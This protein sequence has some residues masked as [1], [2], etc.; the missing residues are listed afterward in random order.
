MHS[1]LLQR[2]EGGR[3]CLLVRPGAGNGRHPLVLVL[4]GY[5]A[6]A[7]QVMGQAYP[8][9]PLALWRQL[10]ERE[11]LLLAAPQGWRRSWNA[12]FADARNDAPTDD[13]GFI[14]ALIEHLVATEHADPERVFVVGSSKGGM[15]ALRLA[16]DLAPRLAAVAALLASLPQHACYAAPAQ[17]PSMLLLAGSADP[18]VPYGGGWRWLT[19]PGGRMLGAE[20]SVAWWRERAGLSQVQPTHWSWPGAAQAKGRTRAERWIWG[21]DPAGRQLGFIRIEGG[22]HAEPSATQRY[23]KLLRPLIGVQNADFEIVEAV[24]EFFRLKRRPP[25]R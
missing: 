20:A 3:S 2:P 13:V 5:Q 19:R 24:W 7:A 10:A 9:S 4:H 18:L 8:P 25:G 23:P 21:D 15:M 6:S 22:G 14:A 11:G 17:A 16:C 1:F 12:G